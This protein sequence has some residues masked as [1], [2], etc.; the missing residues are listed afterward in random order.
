V[1]EREPHGPVSPP[2]TARLP[3]RT[4]GAMGPRRGKPEWAEVTTVALGELPGPQ[5][6]ATRGV[7]PVQAE[8][9]SSCSRLTEHATCTRLA[10][11]ETPRRGVDPAALVCG[12]VA[13]ADGCQPFF[14]RHRPDAVRI[15]DFPQAREHLATAAQ[16]SFGPGTAEVR[17]WLETQAQLRKHA[18]PATVLAA[19]RARPVAQASDP[20]AARQQREEA[21]GDFPT[22]LAPIASADF[23][24]QGYPIGS[25]IVER[26]NKL[27]VEA[28]RKGAGLHGARVPVDPMVALRTI[29]CS[30][31]GEEAGP[32]IRTQL[33]ATARQRQRARHHARH[34]APPAP[35]AS[36]PEP[37]SAAKGS[38]RTPTADGA[39]PTMVDGRPPAAHPWRRPLRP[40]WQEPA[41]L[42]AKL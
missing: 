38:T 34:P 20:H 12:V 31:R 21:L 36:G 17:Q 6:N 15:L 10:L 29:V 26:A 9:L 16:A 7:W 27:V 14:E 3:V 8:H 25:G 37:A 33:R 32:Q 13:G 30:D 4:D 39:P 41:A 18:T 22:R 42:G 23:P 1:E 11:V 2:S 19:L 24:A 5:W 28:R 35:A 40:E